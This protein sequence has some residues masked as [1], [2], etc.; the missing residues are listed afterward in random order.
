MLSS[1]CGGQ[2]VEKA[3]LDSFQKEKLDDLLVIKLSIDFDIAKKVEDVMI[4]FSTTG[5]QFDGVEDLLGSKC[6]VSHCTFTYSTHDFE[7]PKLEVQRTGD[8]VILGHR[9]GAHSSGRALYLDMANEEQ[10]H[11][12]LDVYLAKLCPDVPKVPVDLTVYRISFEINTKS[13]EIK[14]DMEPNEWLIPVGTRTLKMVF[15]FL[16]VNYELEG[17]KR[18]K[19]RGYYGGE[20]ELV[21]DQ[22]KYSPSTRLVKHNLEGRNGESI[23]RFRALSYSATYS[24]PGDSSL[25]VSLSG[26]S[27]VTLIEM[28]CDEKISFPA[29]FDIALEYSTM[30]LKENAGRF[31]MKLASKDDDGL[32]LLEIVKNSDKY[33]FVFGFGVGENDSWKSFGL[34]CFEPFEPF[35]LHNL[36]LVG[37]SLD[38]DNYTFPEASEFKAPVFEGCSINVPSGCSIRKGLHCMGEWELDTANKAQ[39]FLKNLLGLNSSVPV[40]ITISSSPSVMRSNCEVV[41]VDGH[42]ANVEFG[43]IVECQKKSVSF[44][45]KG[46]VQLKTMKASFN[47]S[48]KD[49][50]SCVLVATVEGKDV[51][52]GT[53]DLSS[54]LKTMNDVVNELEKKL[55]KK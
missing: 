11:I 21:H 17:K 48:I 6:P 47:V 37:S 42:K 15:S 40:V 29:G 16:Y 22:E 38:R 5:S 27:V 50:S 2:D 34:G 14:G 19:Y 30:I 20:I 32:L 3:L 41:L 51:E 44:F 23:P 55:L 43:A 45:A 4:T 52:I 36:V 35:K 39:Q 12:P 33:G 24:V 28:F 10:I 8:A 25:F 7:G 54:D 13:L 49:D 18:K 46:E 1:L 53:F 31:D 26:F 9:F